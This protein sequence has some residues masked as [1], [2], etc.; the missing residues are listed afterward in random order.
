MTKRGLH[1]GFLSPNQFAPARVT[2][3]V[4]VAGDPWCCFSGNLGQLISDMQHQAA[5]TPHSFASE[6]FND[7]LLSITTTITIFVDLN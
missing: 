2:S 5:S 3:R 1:V 4:P 7:G 6:A